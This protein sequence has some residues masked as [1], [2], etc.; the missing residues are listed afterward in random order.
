MR[1]AAAE[2][3]AELQRLQESG[4]RPYTEAYYPWDPRAFGDTFRTT[5]GWLFVSGGRIVACAL[6][7]READHW[8]LAEL[9]VHAGF[10]GRGLG[11]ALAGRVIDEADRHDLPLR[12]WVLRNNPARHLYLRLGFRDRWEAPFHVV[13]E[14]PGAPVTR[15]PA[16]PCY[17]RSSA[18]EFRTAPT[19]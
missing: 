17:P 12:L 19:S 7:R 2:D 8:F 9:H 15:P 6:F 13:M 10:R 4:A 11:S 5:E 3:Q 16:D 18:P 14:R 1:R